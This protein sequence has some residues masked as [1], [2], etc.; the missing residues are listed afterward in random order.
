MGTLTHMCKGCSWGT[1]AHAQRGGRSLHGHVLTCAHVRRGCAGGV[2]SGAVGDMSPWS[3]PGHRPVPG[4]RTEGWGTLVYRVP[5]CTHYCAQRNTKQE[6]I[7]EPDSFFHQLTTS[8]PK[9]KQRSGLV[10]NK[11][12]MYLLIPTRVG[13]FFVLFYKLDTDS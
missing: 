12:S 4:P 6:K 10:F 2:H 11:F 1:C 8:H 13:F 7:P 9:A 3:S 5:S